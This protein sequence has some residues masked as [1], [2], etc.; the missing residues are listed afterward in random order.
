MQELPAKL[1]FI[2]M[3]APYAQAQAARLESGLAPWR[4]VQQQGTWNQSG[5]GTGSG[6]LY[7]CTAPNTWSLFYTPYT[8]PHPLQALGPSQSS[9]TV[10]PSPT[11]LTV[12]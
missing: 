10:I 3:W 1:T 8:Y 5:D 4:T 11:E 6:V 2:Q 12:R 9:A 7:K